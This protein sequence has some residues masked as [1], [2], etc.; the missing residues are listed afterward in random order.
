[1]LVAD[2][3]NAY[4]QVMVKVYKERR[5]KRTRRTANIYITQQSCQPFKEEPLPLVRLAIL[6]KSTS[7]S[8][9][10]PPLLLLLPFDTL[11]KEFMLS[12]KFLVRKKKRRE[13]KARGRGRGRRSEKEDITLSSA[14]S[15]APSNS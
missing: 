9:S 11:Y 8:L 6:L 7:S 5:V 1:M 2:D 12:D 15:E 13:E 14:S 4:T 3:N 10:P